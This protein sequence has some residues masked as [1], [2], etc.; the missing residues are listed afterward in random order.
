MAGS[1]HINPQDVKMRVSSPKRPKYFC[2]VLCLMFLSGPL[3]H[4]GSSFVINDQ[5]FVAHLMVIAR[6]LPDGP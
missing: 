1:H 6:G 2:P 3:D 4:F 5:R